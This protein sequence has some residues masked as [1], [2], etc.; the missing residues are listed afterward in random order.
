M[1]ETKL[2][3]NDIA[4]MLREQAPYSPR[5][6]KL[7][8]GNGKEIVWEIEP[9]SGIYNLKEEKEEVAEA[10]EPKDTLDE[11]PEEEVKE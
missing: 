5:F 11:N 6:I 2:T 1:E 3:I 10:E 7:N 9:R 4:R 8:L